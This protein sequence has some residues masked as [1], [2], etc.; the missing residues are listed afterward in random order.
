M[1]FRDLGLSAKLLA[2]LDEAGY[3]QPVQA[4]GLDVPEW[5]MASPSSRAARREPA[6]P[7][8]RARP[9]AARVLENVSMPTG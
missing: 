4:Q 7:R 6:P 3:S 1:S 5:R 9:A 8:A 2:A